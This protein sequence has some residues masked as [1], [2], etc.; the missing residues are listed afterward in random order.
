VIIAQVIDPCLGHT[1]YVE[2]RGAHIIKLKL[3]GPETSNILIL[4][5]ETII[6]IRM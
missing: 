1:N 5:S 6:E 3:L 2:I 4:N